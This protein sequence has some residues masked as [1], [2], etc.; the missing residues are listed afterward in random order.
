MVSTVSSLDASGIVP[1]NLLSDRLISLKLVREDI[2][3][4]GQVSKLSWTA[5]VERAVRREKCAQ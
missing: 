1:E 2:T 5:S 3:S 4:R